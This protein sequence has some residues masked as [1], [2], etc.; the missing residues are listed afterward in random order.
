MKKI[1]GL[2]RKKQ[3]FCTAVGLNIF[4][5]FLDILFCDV[6][7]EVS[8]DFIMASIMSGAFGNEANPQLIFMN[9]ILGY[10]LLPM[11]KVF[12]S[13]SWYFVLQ[14]FT[15]FLSFSLVSYMLLKK[16][17]KIL[18]VFLS[19]LFILFFSDDVYILPQ[20]TKSSMLVMMSGSVVFLWSTFEKKSLK[21]QVISGVICLI[22]S[23]LRIDSVYLS[24]TFLLWLIICEFISIVKSKEKWKKPF[25]YSIISGGILIILAFGLKELDTITYLNDEQSKYF[26]E[27]NI[28]RSQIVD[29]PDYGYE[30]YAKELQKIGISENDYHIL[31]A[32]NFA[33]NNIFSLEMMQKIAEIITEGNHQQTVELENLYEQLQ[34]RKIFN[35]PIAIACIIISILY[36][37]FQKKTFRILIPWLISIAL[38]LYFFSIGRVLYRVE[39]GIFIGMF[40]SILYFWDDTQ[41]RFKA[42]RDEIK[43][44]LMVG[45]II[46]CLIKL[47]LYIP[48]LTY[49]KVN[50]D[51]RKQYIDSVFNDSWN[52]DARKY[53]KIVNKGKPDNDLLEEIENNRDNFYFLDFST[54]IQSLYYEWN[55]FETLPINYFQNI[56]YLTGVTTNFPGTDWVLVNKGVENPL[57]S[58]V[59]DNVYLVDNNNLE[60]KL[61]YLREHYYPNVRAELYKTTSGYKI[62]KLYEN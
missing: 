42:Y 21:I 19:L 35:Y 27:Y 12:P 36:I 7:Y 45:I 59:K 31:R 14:I 62:W 32:W 58:L 46:L 15:C 22:G 41:I 3:D 2:I 43:S 11:Y 10:L 17:P 61:N 60:I 13:V 52:Y 44:C 53:R 33:D 6:K 37:C 9:T 51:T 40:L 8:D 47:P 48:D 4:L 23:M 39:Y 30:V 20:F 29:S 56:Y 34:T 24:G 5:L 26:R 38:E 18:A 54:T 49:L 28:A 1:Y 16:H 55:P 25:L 57:P 50:S